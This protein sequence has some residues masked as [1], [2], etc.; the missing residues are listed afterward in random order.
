MATYIK[1]DPHKFGC[2]TRWLKEQ[3]NGTVL[4]SRTELQ[5]QFILAYITIT[6]YLN[7]W[8]EKGVIKLEKPIKSCNY[9]KIADVPEG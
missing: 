1:F 5:S 3:P 4:P 6:A 8:V 2:F 7:Y 9:T